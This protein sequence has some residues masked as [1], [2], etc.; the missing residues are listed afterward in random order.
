MCRKVLADGPMQAAAVSMGLCKECLSNLG[1]GNA[2]SLFALLD[3]LEVPVLISDWSLIVTYA[4][5]AAK[6]V[7]GEPARLLEG[8]DIGVVM[9]C[10][11]AKTPGACGAEPECEGC[12]LR[13]AI[14]DT[15]ADAQPRYGGCAE[16]KLGSIPDKR[17]R[18]F[19]FST[20]RL[21][22]VIVLSFD[23]IRDLPWDAR[24]A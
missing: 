1:L 10:A 7:F 5:Q 19:L 24:L 18:R 15:Y 6:R 9:E 23:D 2:L 8:R 13:K 3:R 14:V 17:T 21:G 11:C 12:R 4:N 16:L 22:S 20:A